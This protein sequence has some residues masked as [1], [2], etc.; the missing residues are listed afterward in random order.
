MRFLNAGALLALPFLTSAAPVEDFKASKGYQ[1]GIF[2][3]N[4]A[5]DPL[6]TL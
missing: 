5:S 1:M 3:V 4:W 6:Y 2:Y